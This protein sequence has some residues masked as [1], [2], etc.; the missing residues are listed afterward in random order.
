MVPNRSADKK[1]L[2]SKNKGFKIKIYTQVL[3]LRKR[4]F[5]CLSKSKQPTA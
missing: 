2:R 4:H 3:L 5:L 1:S